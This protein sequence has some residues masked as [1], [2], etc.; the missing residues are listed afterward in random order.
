MLG[1]ISRKMQCGLTEIRVKE[2]ADTDRIAPE[3]GRPAR[4]LVVGHEREVGPGVPGVS[5]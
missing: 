4:E 5:F 1:A 2:A 3:T